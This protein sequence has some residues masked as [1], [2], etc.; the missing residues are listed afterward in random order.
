MQ[1]KEDW[2]GCTVENC[3]FIW[4]VNCLLKN[5]KYKMTKEKVEKI[6]NQQEWRCPRDAIDGHKGLVIM[7]VF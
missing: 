4:H 5:K 1:E 6:K 3:S 7:K 2:L